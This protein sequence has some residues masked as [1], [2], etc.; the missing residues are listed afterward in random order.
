[1]IPLLLLTK[2]HSVILLSFICTYWSQKTWAWG[3]VNPQKESDERDEVVLDEGLV[4]E[5]VQHMLAENTDPAA[6]GSR[7][8]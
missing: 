6:K 2:K 1:M 8:M 7:N 3:L 4:E 5:R